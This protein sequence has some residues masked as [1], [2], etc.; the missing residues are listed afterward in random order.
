MGAVA[1]SFSCH[2]GGPVPVVRMIQAI[3][4][5]LADRGAR[6]II[7]DLKLPE[8]TARKIGPAASAPPRSWSR[9][10]PFEEQ[11]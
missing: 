4:L 1:R 9:V 6:V 10:E 7:T 5:A 11:S 3:A 2:G 8:E